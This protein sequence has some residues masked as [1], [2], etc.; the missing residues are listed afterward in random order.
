MAK[1]YSFDYNREREMELSYKDLSRNQLEGKY[2]DIHEAIDEKIKLAHKFEEDKR[3]LEEQIDRIYNSDLAYEDKREQLC[4]LKEMI[5][6]LQDEYQEQVEKPIEKKQEEAK[7]IMSVIDQHRD[8]L[9]SQANM[10]SNIQLKSG[11]VNLKKAIDATNVIE[12]CFKDLQ[13]DEKR[14]LSERERKIE[15]LRKQMGKDHSRII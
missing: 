14:R 12:E 10:M 5:K 7:E 1:K 8:V 6:V 13:N 2:E 9:K 4:M 15:E 11:S 3:L